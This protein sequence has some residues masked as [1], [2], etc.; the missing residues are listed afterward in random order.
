MTSNRSMSPIV[1]PAAVE[2]PLGRR[3]RA[4]PGG[5]TARRR[6]GTGRRSAPA[7]AGRA[8]GPGPR[9]AS[10]TAA[11][12][13][14]ICE[15]VPAVCTPSGSTGRSRASAVQ[16][17]LPQA[18]VAVDDRGSRR[19]G[20]PSAPS[21]G[22]LT[23]TT[24]RSNRPCAQARCAVAL[25]A[26]AELRRPRPGT[27]RAAARSARPPRTGSAGRCPRSRAAACPRPVPTLA[28]SGTRL[29]ASTPQAMPTSMAPAAISPAMRCAACCAEPHWASR[30]RQPGLV[31]QPG[32]QPGGPGDVAGLLAR[33]GD[34]AAGDLLD[35]RRAR[36]PPAPAARS[37]RRRGS[38][39]ACRPAS[40]P[41]RLPIGVRTA[42]TIT[43]VP[44]AAPPSWPLSASSIV[45]HV[46]ILAASGRSPRPWP[47]G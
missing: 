41:P 40:T 7:A 17:G 44:T 42:S 23:G 43:A 26:Q 29:I 18:L 3:D 28:P 37:A 35:A 21:T 15:D 39:P 14:E 33:L 24:S 20:W 32:V 38:R 22:A 27:A 8:P 13:S 1:M 4:R 5:S 45:E 30:V 10:S 31:G 6:P 16:A 11:A 19:S 36:C 2:H 9:R 47:H 34:A 12:P 46:L 25:R